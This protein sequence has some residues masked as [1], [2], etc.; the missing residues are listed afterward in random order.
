METEE[1]VLYALKEIK[2]KK[3]NVKSVLDIGSGSGCMGLSA[4]LSLKACKEL[5]LIEPSTEALSSL[6]KNISRFQ[7][8][9]KSI[10]LISKKFE[11][12]SLDKTPEGAGLD[13]ASKDVCLNKTDF[14]LILSNPPY[15]PVDDPDVQNSVYLYEPHMSLFGGVEPAELIYD[16]TCKAFDML[17]D[18]G[19]MFF[20]FSHDQK[21]KLEKS[22]DKFEPTFFEDSFGKD[23][24]FMIDKSK[25]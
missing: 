11:D 18:K 10:K 2:N 5:V 9:I 25:L 13:K 19:L 8:K 15:I 14:D 12:V 16:W 24:F 7:D 3:L 17:S 23:R 6:N 21:E 4:A 22:L 20:E 1:I